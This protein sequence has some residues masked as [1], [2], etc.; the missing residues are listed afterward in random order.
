M[1]LTS[2][3]VQ[4]PRCE[5]R[6]EEILDWLVD[7]HTRAAR[8]DGEPAEKESAFRDR[9]RRLVRHVACGPD[10]IAMRGYSAPELTEAGTTAG[11]AARTDAFAAE[12]ET[13][14]KRFYA[15]IDE[16]PGDL[17][18]VTCTGY[19]APSGAQR[20]VSSKGWGDHTRITHAYHMGCYAAVPAL[21]VAMGCFSSARSSRSEGAASRR[22]DV[23]HTE[24]C[25]LHF[26]PSIHTPEQIVVQ[27]LFA[28]GAIRYE[29]HENVNDGGDPL[30]GF[31]VL[32]L[33]EALV[34]GS[35]D[36]MQW[37]LGDRGMRMS[38]S[39]NVPGTIGRLIRSFVGTLFERAGVDFAMERTKCAFAVHPGGPKIIDAVRDALELTEPQ[40]EASRRVLRRFGNMSSATLP[41]IWCEILDGEVP[42][43]TL[44]G[45]IAFGPGLT[46]CGALFRKE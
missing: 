33:H 6:Q 9:M 30:H 27:S 45:S 36:E 26:D 35:E 17:V 7:V 37:L 38:L 19:V 22:V 31:R 10:K 5:A 29:V 11:T 40:I 25:S 3:E 24:L 34:P 12:V 16:P 1:L 13:V 32:A 39:R 42:R 20:I 28:D 46:L 44:V 15:N 41:H 14:F 2:F 23:V 21:R 4:R 43:G 8:V 18:H